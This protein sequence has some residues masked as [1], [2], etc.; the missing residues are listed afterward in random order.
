MELIGALAALFAFFNNSY[1][2][3]FFLWGFL[4]VLPFQPFH[5][6]LGARC[7]VLVRLFLALFFISV[8]AFNDTSLE[9]VGHSIIFIVVLIP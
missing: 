3:D 6:W 1:L 7:W 9:I 5:E 4:Q 2:L 8:G